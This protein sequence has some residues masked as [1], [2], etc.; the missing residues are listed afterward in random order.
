MVVRNTDSGPTYTYISLRI[1]RAASSLLFS[2]NQELQNGP[3]QRSLAVLVMELKGLFMSFFFLTFILKITHCFIAVKHWIF[4]I[5]SG[6]IFRFNISLSRTFLFFR[7]F[8]FF[9]FNQDNWIF[10]KSG[11]KTTKFKLCLNVSLPAMLNALLTGA[12]RHFFS[13]FALLGS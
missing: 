7:F 1:L 6:L 5:S 13:I 10:T 8:F 9:W 12:P 4:V 2:S 11:V 3:N